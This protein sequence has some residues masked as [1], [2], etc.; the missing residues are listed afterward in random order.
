MPKYHFLSRY[1]AQPEHIEH[2]HRR[3]NTTPS[4]WQTHT[5]ALALI[6]GARMEKKVIF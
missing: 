2:M 4:D 3:H 1:K 6:K 5:I